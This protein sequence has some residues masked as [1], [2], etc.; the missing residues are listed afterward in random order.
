MPKF[1]IAWERL[2]ASLSG[3]KV[4]ELERNYSYNLPTVHNIPGMVLNKTMH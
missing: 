1:L 2:P 4:L 3:E